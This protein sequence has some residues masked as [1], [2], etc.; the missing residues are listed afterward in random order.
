MLR[1][2]IPTR[3]ILSFRRLAIRNRSF[4][5]CES[6][7]ASP[8]VEVRTGDGEASGAKQHRASHYMDARVRRRDRSE[9]DR[10][11]VGAARE[12]GAEGALSALPQEVQEQEVHQHG[13]A[14]SAFREEAEAPARPDQRPAGIQIDDLG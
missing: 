10:L 13:G 14:G 4:N 6:R 5:K 8:G 2:N 12:R 9:D 1:K 7:D 11:A 3:L